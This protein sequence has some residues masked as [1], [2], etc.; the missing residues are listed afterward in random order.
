MVHKTYKPL[1]NFVGPKVDTMSSAA[2]YLTISQIIWVRVFNHHPEVFLVSENS[3]KPP[4]EFWIRVNYFGFPNF[5]LKGATPLFGHSKFKDWPMGE[6]YP[7][8]I[9]HKL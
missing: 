2:S 7:L 9:S 3:L 8:V 5:T 1:L 4:N 6:P